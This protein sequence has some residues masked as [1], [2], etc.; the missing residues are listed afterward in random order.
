MRTPSASLTLAAALLFTCQLSGAS[1]PDDA[2]G[3]ADADGGVAPYREVN[4]TVPTGSTG[5]TASLGITV[6]TRAGDHALANPADVYE[7]VS[8]GWEVLVESNQAGLVDPKQMGKVEDVPLSTE[9]AWHHYRASQTGVVDSGRFLATF[10]MVPSVQTGGSRLFLAA[11]AGDA[12]LVQALLTQEDSFDVN[13]Q[14]KT[15]GNTALHAAATTCQPETMSVLLAHGALPTLVGRSGASPLMMAATIGCVDGIR[16]ILAHA[17]KESGDGGVESAAYKAV[18]DQRHPF[19]GNTALHFAAEMGRDEAVLALC[20]GGADILSRKAKTGGTALHTAADT[21]QTGAVDALLGRCVDLR[22]ARTVAADAPG[23]ADATAGART[24]YLSMLM[25]ED[26]T[27]LYLAAQRGLHQI[28]KVI[29]GYGAN[30]DYVMPTGKFHGSL[31]RVGGAGGGDGGGEEAVSYGEKNTEI[32]N[33]ATAIH[34]AAENGHPQTVRTLLALGAR[35]LPTMQ[36]TSPLLTAVQ[37]D[38]PEIAQDLLEAMTDADEAACYDGGGDLVTPAGGATP[39]Y[40]AAGRGTRFAKLVSTL[41]ARRPAYARA[42]LLHRVPRDVTKGSGAVPFVD[43]L[44]HALARGNAPLAVEMLRG[45]GGAAQLWAAGVSG[46]PTAAAL[47]DGYAVA[48]LEGR[49]VEC[50]N[51]VLSVEPRDGGAGGK[52]KNRVNRRLFGGSQTMLHRAI[53]GRAGV[54]VVRTLIDEFTADVRARVGD[55]T[56]ASCA[57]VAV[58]AGDAEVLRVVLAAAD[59]AGETMMA[60]ALAGRGLGWATPLHLAARAGDAKVME[61]LLRHPEGVKG[62]DVALHKTGATPLLE[63]VAGGHAKMAEMLLAGGA[64]AG[65]KVEG[66]G[67]LLHLA[68]AA[69]NGEL[70]RLLEKQGLSYD[71][72]DEAGATPL[73]AALQTWWRGDGGAVRRGPSAE[74]VRHVVSRT[75]V[76]GRTRASGFGALHAAV[77]GGAPVGVLRLLREAGAPLG[78]AADAEATPTMLAAAAQ[79]PAHAAFLLEQGDA[80][81][82]GG[83]TALHAAVDGLE[84]AAAQGQGQRRQYCKVCE[85]LLKAGLDINSEDS[86]GRRVDYQVRAAMRSETKEDG[87]KEEGT[88]AAAAASKPGSRATEQKQKFREAQQRQRQQAE[89]GGSGSDSGE[90]EL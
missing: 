51:V 90:D 35:Q 69:G 58:A 59:K 37:Y 47:R 49:S 83:S 56:K 9:E 44:S 16:A 19:A 41:F 21:N 10:T 78:T 75:D 5:G 53:A 73:V 55:S 7:H 27:P 3:D 18:V 60:R 40:E 79:L 82:N 67:S 64:R 88:A 33:G 32:G 30:L 31:Q 87:E 66:G 6:P 11:A 23:F 46:F 76:A 12:R 54:S 26:T 80:A 62:F 89:S 24:S 63:A 84:A 85:V 68:V 39:L 13:E 71:A 86:S 28:V 25:M 15:D 17:K 14:K 45:G 72:A 77:L 48:T 34:A 61:V 42:Q 50:L 22:V 20:E 70:C 81:R 29:A 36:R 43:P 8:K 1:S 4:L 52:N 65:V 74:V 38:H 57:H 2:S